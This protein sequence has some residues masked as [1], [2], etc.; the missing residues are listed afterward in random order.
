FVGKYWSFSVKCPFFNPFQFSEISS[1]VLPNVF[2]PFTLFLPVL[3][4]GLY[5]VLPFPNTSIFSNIGSGLYLA[6]AGLPVSFLFHTHS[7]LNISGLLIIK[8]AAKGFVAVNTIAPSS[9]NILLYSFHNGSNG[10]IVSHLQCV[11]P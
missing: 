6:T 8:F 2:L 3:I 5:L 4:S 9:F 7:Y 11:S 1:P 10:I